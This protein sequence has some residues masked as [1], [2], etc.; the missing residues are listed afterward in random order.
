MLRIINPATEAVIDELDT[1]TADSVA[2]KFKAAKFAQKDWAAR[3]LQD[4][5]AIIERFGSLLQ[6]RKDSLAKTLSSEMGKP[7]GQAQG[8]IEAVAPRVAYFL[9]QVPPFL[10]EVEVHS[11]QNGSMR[12]LLTYEPLG[13]I[14]NISAWNYPFFVGANVFLPALLTGNA[15]MYKPSEFAT[16]TGIGIAEALHDAGVPE[17]VFPVLIGGGD[18]GAALLEQDLGGVYFTGSHAT[19]VKVAQAASKKLMRVQLELGGKDPAYVCDD[20]DA[21]SAAQSLASGVFYNTGQSCC[22]IERVYVHEKLYDAFVDAFLEEVASFK[23]GDPMQEGIFIG[24]LTRDPQ[25]A[26]LQ[27]Q[28]DDAL[29]KGA[30]LRCGGARVEGPGYYYQP[31]VLTEVNGQMD[32]MREESFGPIIGIEKVADD[33][34]ALA[35][36]NESRYGLTASVFCQSEERARAIMA[37]LE[38]GSAYWNCCD[39]VSPNL[40]WTG[41]KDSGIGSTLGLDGIRAFLQSKGWHLRRP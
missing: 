36:M 16:L 1:D 24:P 37:K 5:I 6:E 29:A 9:K 19:G 21:K 4:R 26:V 25:R 12:E 33:A 39:R 40:P 3:P 10:D 7:V 35:A 38:A 2:V 34:S 22:S 11:T 27:K 20:V 23:M 31:T 28:V 32:V 41:W 30:T 14:G 15:V 17:E 8:E 13:V 18:V